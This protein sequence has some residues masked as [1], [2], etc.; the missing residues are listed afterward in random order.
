MHN[1]G[2]SIARIIATSNL[3]LGRRVQISSRKP[4]K[5]HTSLKRIIPEDALL[6]P[7]PLNITKPESLIPAFK[8]ADVVVS[9]VG[10]MHGS[11][12]DFEEIQWKGAENVANATRE[13]GAKL[14]HISAIGADSQSTVPYARTKGLAEISALRICPDAT[15]VRPSIVFGPDDDFFSVCAT[16]HTPIQS[17][18]QRIPF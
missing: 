7:V 3:S 9:L 18:K 13:V 14:I 11:P 12:R 1:V 8:D 5:L 2:S 6:P 15:I 16:S 10:L 17:V 4:D